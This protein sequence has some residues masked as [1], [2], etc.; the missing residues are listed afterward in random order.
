MLGFLGMMLMGIV[1]TLLVGSLGSVAVGAVGVG[2]SMSGL[3]FLFGLGLLLGIDR[4]VAVAHGA[5]R[6]HDVARVHAHGI[7]LALFTSLPL[8][9][10][11][12]LVAGQLARM[13]VAPELVPMASAWLRVASWSLVPA[14]LFTAVRGSLQALGD[15]RAATAILLSANAVNAFFN[16]ALIHGRWGLPRLG[17]EGSAWATVIARVYTAALLLGWSFYRGPDLREIERRIHWPTMRELL[18]LGG[19]ASVQLIFEGGIFALVT[20]LC[21]RIGAVAAAAHNVAMQ[22]SS[23]T[24]MIPLGLSTAGSV[25]VGNAI[26][27]NDLRAAARAGWS[28]VFFGASFMALSGVTMLATAHLIVSV[29][30]LDD[31][32]ASLARSLLMCVAVFQLF[33][34][35]QVTLSG[36]LRG[37]GDTLA[38]M[39]ANLVGH[40]LIGLPVGCALAFVADRGALGLWMGLATGLG[41]VATALMLIWR[42]R[43]AAIVRGEIVATP[44]EH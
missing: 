26:G 9:V 41:A 13:G 5:G 14:L 6:S 20:L 32:S 8:S 36:V 16:V 43:I 1:D 42:R 12:W 3:A 18:R 22:V 34:G 31:A 25:R 15:T 29:F 39:L 44:A 27:R 24:F 11:L 37:S 17:I 35:C 38:S 30:G 19:P 4:Q 10:G 7:A 2:S 23:F 28:A 21:A 40:W 33:D